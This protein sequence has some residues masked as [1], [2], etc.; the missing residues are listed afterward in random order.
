MSDEKKKRAGEAR[1]KGVPDEAKKVLVSQAAHARWKKNADDVR[2]ADY[3]GTIELAGFTLKCAVLDD[4]TRVLSERSVSAALDH[5]RHPADY[6]RKQV[7]AGSG[8]EILPAFMPSVV[9]NFLPPAVRAQLANPIRYQWQKGFGIPAIGVKADLLADVCEAFLAAREAGLLPAEELGTARAADRLIRALARVAIIALIDEATGYQVVRDR[10]ELQKLL[11]KYVSE[12]HRT[13]M[14]TFPNEFYVE[15]FR[16]RNVK[17]D[18]IRKKPQYFGKLTNDLVYSRLLPGMLPKLD[19]VN[20]VNAQ[21]RRARKHH[22]HL[23]DQGEEH[24]KRHL[25]GLVYLMRSSA[26]WTE[27]MKA[28][29]RAA[30][31]QS[32][33]EP[34]GVVDNTDEETD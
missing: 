12:E 26:N 19:S 18:D 24:L 5:Q 31:V 7:A 17:T 23:L 16:L 1:W 29:N 4:A 6:E 8:Q 13:W 30:P 2:V 3:P 10:D 9:A 32:E 25:A 22:Q 33:A 11:S 21:G 34:V 28:V 15:L 20:P 27:F 14:Q